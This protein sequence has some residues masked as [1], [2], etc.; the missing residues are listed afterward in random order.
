[1]SEIRNLLPDPHPVSVSHWTRIG[2]GESDIQVNIIAN[3]D[4]P[5]LEV[6]NS[7]GG[8]GRGVGLLMDLPEGEYVFGLYLHW[9]N[10]Y[11]IGD[12]WIEVKQGDVILADCGYNGYGKYYLTRFDVA[13]NADIQIIL[14]LPTSSSNSRFI[15]RYL[16]LMTKGDWDTM[17]NLKNSDGTAANVRWFAPPKNAA[18]GVMSAPVL[19]CG[20]VIEAT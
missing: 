10:A 3:N 18:A 13:Q 15:S 9:A 20:G 14:Y 2:G 11:N 4:L 7:T 19:D 16:L 5:Q 12:Q 6:R 8:D 1:M 17:R